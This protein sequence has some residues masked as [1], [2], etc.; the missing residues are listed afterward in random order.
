MRRLIFGTGLL[1]SLLATPV[2]AQ[3]GQNQNQPN[4][5][6]R[7]LGQRLGQFGRNLFGASDQQSQQQQYEPEP[8]YVQPSYAGQRTP[9]RSSQQ[10]QNQKP[11]APQPSNQAFDPF[12][13]TDQPLRTSGKSSGG[14]ANA[15][16]SSR[17][18]SSIGPGRLVEQDL[19]TEESA[20]ASSA[21]AQRKPAPSRS[22]SVG[23]AA[24]KAGSAG[25]TK[26]VA[27]SPKHT[28]VPQYD[29]ERPVSKSSGSPAEVA[30]KP[31]RSEPITSADDA[32]PLSG[33][34]LSS[35]T[36][37][38][39]AKNMSAAASKEP[40]Y[41]KESSPA[42]TA[43]PAKS[44][45]P[46]VAEDRLLLSPKSPMISVQTSGPR[47]ITV[48]KEAQY[49]IAITNAGEATASDVVVAIAIPAWADVVDGRATIGSAARADA[50]GFQW[51]IPSLAVQSHHELVLKLIP[52]KSQAFDLAVRWSCAPPMTQATVEVQEPKL[53][54]NISGPTDV[55]YG[56]QH[57]Y[58]LTVSNPGNGDADDVAI[59]LLPVTP[60]EGSTASH[61]VGKLKA[62]S[63]MSVEIELT[64]RQAGKLAIR[65][66]AT[67]EAGLQ[68][69]AAIDVWVRRAALQTT[70][71]MP[72]AHYA[73]AP[74]Q[75]E[76]RIANPG[77][78]AASKVAVTV[79]L[80]PGSEFIGA[81]DGGSYQASRS[82]VTWLLDELAAGSER[83][84]WFK[85]KTKSAGTA[86]VEAVA[87][88]EA[89]LKSNAMA[90]TEIMA[91]ADLVLDVAD[92]A[93]PIPVG[94][95]M[96]YTVR[97]RNR[98]TSMAHDVGMV[99]YFSEGIEPVAVEGGGHQIVPGTVTFKPISLAAGGEAV[100]SVKARAST[101]GNHQMR[102]EMECKPLGTRLT[103][104]L[105]TLF[106]NDEQIA[107]KPPNTET[108]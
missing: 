34:R 33:E 29:A 60:G 70:V 71:V 82:E 32:E 10:Q 77:D 4:Y 52:R 99:A 85:Y 95:D 37:A 86:R 106:Y 40:T 78:A 74:L 51:T 45:A 68:S 88:A 81:G 28:S 11:R 44:P 73:G 87:I 96:V 79:T 9:Q 5:Q 1:T 14:Q 50:D 39:S 36:Q 56:Q 31:R 30:S 24:A 108:R 49:T 63:S 8:G 13:K 17:K 76:V 93:G 47:K 105:T 41:V 19:A 103:Q 23:S 54:M 80:P 46:R 2:L 38:S 15:P 64:A 26:S 94:D 69:H 75:G 72:K 102:V 58:K 6:Q 98:G 59:H 18:P 65:A 7:T 27:S 21:T 92:P 25:A 91:V 101:G 35:G 16:T 61:K 22:S 67:G 3:N 55:T 20:P 57:L 48:G 100:Y 84:L 43:P 97:L 53:H 83:G 12:S 104:E 66:D 89:D 42:T 62:G 90:A 107:T